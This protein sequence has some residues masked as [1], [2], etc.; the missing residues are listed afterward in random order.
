MPAGAVPGL[1]QRAEVALLGAVG[2]HRLAAVSR[3]AGDVVQQRGQLPAGTETGRIRHLDPFQT[4]ENRPRGSLPT[5][6]QAFTREQATASSMLPS[7]AGA[8]TGWTFHP[9]PFHRS[10]SGRG[11]ARPLANEPTAVHALVPEHATAD[12]PLVVAPAGTGTLACAQPLPFQRSATGTE[13]TSPDGL[14]PTPA[15]QRAEPARHPRRCQHRPV[16]P[17]PPAQSS[18]DPFQVSA[19]SPK[20]RGKSLPATATARRRRRARHGTKPLISGPGRTGGGACIRHAGLPDAAAAIAG[21]GTGTRH[22]AGRQPGRR[23]EHARCPD[24]HQPP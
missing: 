21:C 8:G 9:E 17:A 5:A 10:A 24:P 20:P 13:L 2:A 12:S 6:R 14:L 18:R 15:H 11:A 3:R 16:R 22:R 4:S 7:A 23:R 19:N 1:G